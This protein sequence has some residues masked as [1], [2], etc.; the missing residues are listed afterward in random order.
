MRSNKILNALVKTAT[1]AGVLLV[2]GVTHAADVYLQTE[3]YSKDL[4]N[5]DAVLIESVDMWRFICDPDKDTVT[6]P[7]CT[8]PTSGSPQIS[9]A[10]G[11]SLKIYLNDTLST[12]VSIMIRGQMEELAGDAFPATGRVRSFAHETAAGSSNTYTWSSLRAGTYLYQSGTHPSIQVPMGLYGALVVGSPVT[13]VGCSTGQPAYDD[14]DSCYDDEVV[15]LFSELDPVQNRA[16][17][18]A[19]GIVSDYPSTIN[20]SPTYLLVN[21]DL[22]ANFDGIG[23]ATGVLPESR[24]VLLRLLNAGSRSHTPAIVGLDMTL[25]A[26]DGN[27]YPGNPLCRLRHCCQPARRSTLSSTR[28]PTMRRSVYTIERRT[29]P[30]LPCHKAG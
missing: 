5:N 8:D 20:Y 24:A 3:S 25:I 23:D 19:G 14:D 10:E 28:P 9:L 11:D 2:S 21:G 6:N 22:S 7:H 1:L 4:N 16:V 17:S 27:V 29:S 15:M 18:G 13:A 12:A 26:E 30:T